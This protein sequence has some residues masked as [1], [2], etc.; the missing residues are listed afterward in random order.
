MLP[1]HAHLVKDPLVL[2]CILEQGQA[3]K[4]RVTSAACYLWPLLV[5]Y[6]GSAN[7]YISLHI[8][9]YVEFVLQPSF[10]GICWNY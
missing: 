5:N 3:E 7:D 1:P 10:M 8:H 6:H 4:G 9:L 2:V